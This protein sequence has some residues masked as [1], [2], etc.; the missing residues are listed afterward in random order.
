MLLA[1][2]DIGQISRRA[3]LR[4]SWFQWPDG[5]SF[6]RLEPDRGNDEGR[7]FRLL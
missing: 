7:V 4:D 3:L 1:A 2:R 5:F 6:K